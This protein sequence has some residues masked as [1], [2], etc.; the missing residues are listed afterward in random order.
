M[1]C[2]SFDSFTGKYGYSVTRDVW[3]SEGTITTPTES[4]YTF[5]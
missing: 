1:Y 2:K 4:R 3:Q 5:F